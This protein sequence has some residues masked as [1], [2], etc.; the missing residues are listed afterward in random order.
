MK[1]NKIYLIRMM[2][3]MLFL[4]AAA[5]CSKN[6]ND[7]FYKGN[8]VPVTVKGFNA[9]E[10]ELLVKLDTF[11]YK[12]GLKPGKVFDQ[13][14]AYTFLGDDKP[15]TLKVTEKS[16]EK[17]VLEKQ[18][19]K[20]DGP[21][22]INFFYMDG[23]VSDMPQ[24]LPI[25]EG[26]IK[27]S[28][29]F[30]PL[31]TK[32]KEPVD[33]AF[34]KYYFF[35]KVSEEIVRLKNVK[36]NEFSETVTIPTFPSSGLYNGKKTPILFRAYIYKAGTN[37]FYTDGTAYT[38]NTISSTAPTPDSPTASSKA[39]IFFDYANDTDITFQTLLEL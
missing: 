20:G 34:I 13:T 26:K 39:Y 27:I 17:V 28:Y 14:Q 37:D 3:I 21:T 9:S 7:F 31:L 33:I 10:E 2:S 8:M 18:V 16:S 23:K 29:L 15:I 22:T 30:K 11:K 24:P 1:L 19:K 36:P 12:D 32:Y 4:L 25:E 5:G 35:P 38:W 6:N